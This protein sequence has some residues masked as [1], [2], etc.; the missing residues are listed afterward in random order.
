[1]RLVASQVKSA[2]FRPKCPPE[3]VLR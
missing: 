1:V 2:S 3:A